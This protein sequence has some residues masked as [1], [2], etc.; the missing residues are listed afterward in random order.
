MISFTDLTKTYDSPGQDKI[1]V[2]DG[3]SFDIQEGSITTIMG[4]SGCGKTTLLNII[5]GLVDPDS[6]KMSCG[7][8]RRPFGDLFY[9]YVFQE[10]RLLDWLTVEE[11]IRFVLKANDVPSTEHQERINTYLKLVDLDETKKSYPGE[12]SGGMQ[13]RVGLA[14]ALAIEP[15][16]ILM[17]EPFGS[18]DEITARD[19]RRDFVSLWAD[20]DTTIVFVTH[21]FQEAVQ[22]SDR[23]LLMNN[24]GKFFHRENIDIPRPRRKNNKAVINRE[25]TLYDIFDNDAGKANE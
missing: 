16:L 25:T 17:D 8:E 23:V 14:R 18:L 13:Q 24:K 19:L 5:A 22:L 15:D 9:G 11:N 10:P 2:L 3:L 20:I 7:G 1:W 21:D 12:L 6:G 4:Q